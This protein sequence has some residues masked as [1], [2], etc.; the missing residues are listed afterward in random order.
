MNVHF[1]QN[2][3]KNVLHLNKN[4][5]T[6]TVVLQ[7]ISHSIVYILIIVSTCLTK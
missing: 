1:Q 4:G 7:Y 2:L 6:V 5:F 3:E